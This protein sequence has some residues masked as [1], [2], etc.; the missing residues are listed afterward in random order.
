MT[1]K[2]NSLRILKRSIRPFKTDYLIHDI[3]CINYIKYILFL[4]IRALLYNIRLQVYLPRH[5]VTGHCNG[6]VKFE[7]IDKPLH[8]KNDSKLK[9]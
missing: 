2:Y 4:K 1:N 5:I 3:K 8:T 7:F 9:I 6:Y